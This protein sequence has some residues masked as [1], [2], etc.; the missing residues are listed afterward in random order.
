MEYIRDYVMYVSIFGMFSFVW[1]G[2]AQERPRPNWRVYI[3]IASGIALLLC[4]L[5]VY[6]SIN[7]WDAPS[8]LKDQASYTTYLIAVYTEFFLAGAGSFVLYRLKRKDY[9]APWI[10][11]IVGIHFLALVSVFK[12]PSLYL[13]TALLVAISFISLWAGPRLKVACSAI[14]GIG[15][16]TVLFAYAILGLIRYLSV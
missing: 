1:F 7:N 15:A 10:L 8:T 14:T 3:G 16:G 12:D 11:F 13:L 6:L 4:L 2:W 9:V 5:G